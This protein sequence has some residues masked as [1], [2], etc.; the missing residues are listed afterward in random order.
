V[1]DGW[2]QGVEAIVQRHNGSSV[3]LRKAAAIAFCSVDSAV[4][5]AS[6]GPVGMSAADVRRFHF[7]TAFWLIS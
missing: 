3:C 1:R 7:A 6:S 2:L 5:L 4:G